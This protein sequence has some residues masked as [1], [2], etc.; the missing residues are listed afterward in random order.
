VTIIERERNRGLSNSVISGVTQLCNEYG[1]AIAVEDDILTAPDFLTFMNRGLERYKDEPKVFSIGAF[2]LPIVT[3]KTY[4]Y[5]AFCSYRFM[6]WGWGTWKD[7]WEK[8]D[9]SVKDFP[10]FVGNR[11]NQRR[12]NQGGDD[13]SWLL[14]MHMGGKID[15][16]DTVWAYAHSKHDA[17]AVLPVISKVYNIGFDG[18]G[19]HCR[20]KQYKQNALGSEEGSSYCFPDFIIAEPFFAREFQRLYHRSIPRKFASYLYDRMGLR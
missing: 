14:T 17:V 6:C 3:P 11:E 12:F 10:E 5:D 20:R 1:R 15:S 7:R 19:I 16:W 18:T 9:W 8:S 13:L 4:R 2:N